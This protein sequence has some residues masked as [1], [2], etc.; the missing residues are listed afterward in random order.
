LLEHRLL[1]RLSAV[2]DENE[3]DKATVA[4]P[5]AAELLELQIASVNER[6]QCVAAVVGD[7]DCRQPNLAT[8]GKQQRT[9]IADVGHGAGTQTGQVAGCLRRYNRNGCARQNPHR[10]N[11]S[12]YLE[13]ETLHE[14]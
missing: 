8:I 4:V 14:L 10:Q 5:L 7:F 2:A 11:Y 13:R 1:N 12:A 3:G 6:L 9:S